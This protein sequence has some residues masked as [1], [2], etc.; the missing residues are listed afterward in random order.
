MEMEKI[1]KKLKKC[2]LTCEHYYPDI[3]ELGIFGPFERIKKEISCLHIPV[4]EKYNDQK[5]KK[6]TKVSCRGYTGELVQLTMRDEID[7]CGRSTAVFDLMI[8]DE[9]SNAEI[10]II[11]VKLEEVKFMHGAVMFDE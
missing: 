3:F 10:S 6:T 1:N 8:L 7:Q 4:C 11:G 5:K 2:C 9:K